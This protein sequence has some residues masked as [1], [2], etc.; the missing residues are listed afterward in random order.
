MEMVYLAQIGFLDK[1]VYLYPE[2][3]LSAVIAGD[4]DNKRKGYIG[5]NQN[6]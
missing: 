5:T 6:G 3:K 2:S 1:C 4:H